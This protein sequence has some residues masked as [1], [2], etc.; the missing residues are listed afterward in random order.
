MK[1]FTRSGSTGFQVWPFSFRQDPTITP[2]A[3]ARNFFMFSGRAPVL[4]RTGTWSPTA[5][6]AS[7][8]QDKSGS[9]PAIGPAMSTASTREE[10]TAL[11]ARWAMLRLPRGEANS[12][13]DVGKNLH[14]VR[15]DLP[16][17]AEEGRRVR[18]PE[19]HVALINSGHHLADESRP[20]R[21][22]DCQRGLCIPEK[23]HSKG[24]ISGAQFCDDPGHHGHGFEVGLKGIGPIVLIAEQ[25]GVDPA[26]QQVEK[27][28]AHRLQDSLDPTVCVIARG[29]GKRREMGHR[30]HRLGNVEHFL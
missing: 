12:G 16:A 17:I 27:V 10:M 6:L 18:G 5:S 20:G 30:D 24:A 7:L 13:R 29:P 23:I 1:A 15:V 11:R 19:A 14:V 21:L 3:T 2:S 8:I 26:V 22:G 9:A 4:S 25:D 28:L